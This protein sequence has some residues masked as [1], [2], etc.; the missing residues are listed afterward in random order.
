MS[1]ALTH[2]E[3]AMGD[4]WF[5]PDQRATVAA[6]M[7]RIIPT[8]DVPGAAEADTITFLDRYLSGP[9]RVYAKP[10]GSGFETLEGK[11]R[12]AWQTRIDVVR[13][14]YT[15]G[16]ERLDAVADERFSARFVELSPE[17]QDAVL[18]AL[19]TPLSDA[20]RDEHQRMALYGAPVEPALQQTSAEVDLG[21]VALLVLHT[22]Q[23]FYA[24]PIYGGN[25]ERVGW[26]VIGFPGPASLSESHEGRFDTLSW[27]AQDRNHCNGKPA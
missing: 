18:T 23:G 7:A 14:I 9:D 3:H 1:T 11:R 15:Q 4:T 13:D 20:Q 26:D 19:D 21:F 2:E 5:D 12:E 27:F 16:I 25:K 24:D 22:R 6:A 17:R 10:D 8:D